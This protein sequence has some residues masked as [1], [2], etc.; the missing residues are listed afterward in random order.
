MLTNASAE[1][2]E[3]EHWLDISNNCAYISDETRNELISLCHKINGLIGGMISK[4][5]RFCEQW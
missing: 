2:N 1:L 5:S 4:A 3:T